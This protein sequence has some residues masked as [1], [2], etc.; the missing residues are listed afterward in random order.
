MWLITKL[1]LSQNIVYEKHNIFTFWFLFWFL[2]NLPSIFKQKENVDDNIRFKVLYW[3]FKT[4]LRHTI[5]TYSSKKYKI[6]K[7]AFDINSKSMVALARLT[8]KKVS[9]AAEKLVAPQYFKDIIYLQVAL[10]V[11]SLWAVS[12]VRA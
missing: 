8:L 6:K 7:A 4:S 5:V 2:F 11:Y 1:T 3:F 9:R 10:N 12:S